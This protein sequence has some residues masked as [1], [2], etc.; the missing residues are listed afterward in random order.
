[1]PAVIELKILDS[2]IGQEIPL[3]HY[4]TAGSAGVF[5]LSFS[6]NRVAL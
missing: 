5:P 2:R 1:M 6:L 4:A 3:P